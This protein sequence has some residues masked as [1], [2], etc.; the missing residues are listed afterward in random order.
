VSGL[1]EQ[2][3][4][5]SYGRQ[6]LNRAGRDP[7][8][9]LRDVIGVSSAHPTAPLSL[10]ARCEP[11]TPDAY[12]DLD[13][14]RLPAMRGA[15]HLLPRETA[16]LA[17]AA[18]PPMAN[19]QAEALEHY[20]LSP[21]EYAAL[22]SR[23]LGAAREPRTARELR[24]AAGTE[25]PLAAVL[26]ALTR[27]GVLIR[28]GAHGLRS[29][30][31]FYVAGHVGA[32]DRDES[33]AWL[34]GQ[35]LRAYGPA[36]PEDFAWWAGVPHEAAYSALERV[37][38]EALEE[39]L[40]L[41]AEDVP[42]FERAAPLRG[43]VDLLPRGDVYTMGYAPNGRGRLGDPDLV[44]ELY[45][46]GGDGRPVV[47][48]DGSAIGTWGV[49]PGDGMEFELNLKERPTPSVHRALDDRAAAIRVL[50]G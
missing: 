44:A 20:G 12:R 27:E 24:E 41:R 23:I 10:L 9:V 39:G 36:R 38:T 35:Y 16:H 31:L 26:A 40:L 14:V 32:A 42:A 17:F 3:R 22:R 46:E 33:L 45:D 1:A 21:E 7:E 48:V 30:E 50:L 47:L 15:I 4:W 19:P 18:V 28:L 37:G 49:R 25:R 8:G 11:L 6:R 43:T 29:N 2:A 13:A 5:F 34:A